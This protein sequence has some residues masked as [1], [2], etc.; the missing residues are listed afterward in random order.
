MSSPIDTDARSKHMRLQIFVVSALIPVWA[1][2]TRLAVAQQTQPPAYSDD[3]T[4][5]AV[6]RV[7][8]AAAD[9]QLAHP[10]DHAPYDWTV[11]AFYTGVMAFSKL[12]DSPRYYDAM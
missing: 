4:H 2:V 9:W 8:T 7:M 3:L 12:S 10:S 1:G 11:A 5:A 6:Q